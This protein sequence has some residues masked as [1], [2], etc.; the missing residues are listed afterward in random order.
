MKPPSPPPRG[1]PK[2]EFSRRVTT[3]RR[4]MRAQKLDSVLLTTEADVRYF[5]G[6]DSPFWRSPTR[7][8]FLLI[9]L[10]GGGPVAV[11]PE[12]GASAF[13]ATWVEDIRTWPSPRPHDEGV[14]LLVDCIRGLPRRFGRIGMP[15]G[16][17]SVAR[18][19]VNDLA[20][21][22]KLLENTAAFEF[23]DA[24]PMLQRQRMVKSTREIAKIRHICRLASA[25]FAALPGFAAAGMS[26]ADI[27]R[28][29]RID[30]L[31]RGVD[32]TPYLAAASGPGGYASIITGPSERRLRG[33]DILVIDTGSTWDGYFCD[34]DRNFAFG[35]APADARAAY[36]V[37][38]RAT[39]AGFAAARP[40]AGT[41]D[42]WRAM[43]AA[44]VAGG[45]RGNTVGRMGHGLGL[46]LTEPPSNAARLGVAKLAPGMVITL[47]PGM[48]FAPGREMVHEENIV[49][50]AAGAEW[51]TE[52]APPELPELP[53]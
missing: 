2:A 38:W 13:A 25:S 19:P 45:S 50:T 51:L 12:I 47:E 3:L 46:Q 39:E 20:R 7:P 48:T 32:D 14:S 1:F 18:M 27:G 49:I 16:A 53:G 31:Q 44:L 30:L 42:V 4:A 5:S 52:R 22:R 8:W 15:L 43:N 10:R 34:F 23:V 21:L 41:A 29:M 37:V 40:G 35:R 28:A 9:P 24:A 36:Q 6:F 11:I 33:G 17:E 26:E